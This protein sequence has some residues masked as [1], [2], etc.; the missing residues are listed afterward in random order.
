LFAPDQ[1]SVTLLENCQH[2]FTAK[3]NRDNR[4]CLFVN[5]EACQLIELGPEPNTINLPT[6]WLRGEPVEVQVRDISG[7]Q[8]YASLAMLSP[9]SL[10][11]EEVLLH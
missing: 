7:S 8:I 2:S 1:S 5:G 3:A 4:F 9:R 10:T 6:R 11:P